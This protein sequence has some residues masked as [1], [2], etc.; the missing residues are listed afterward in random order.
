[1]SKTNQINTP[2]LIGKIE[3]KKKNFQEEIQKILKTSENLDK[4]IKK[5]Y[6]TVELTQMDATEKFKSFIEP[7]K[8]LD[9]L[10]NFYEIFIQCDNDF[11]EIK[12]K[13]IQITNLDQAIENLENCRIL[14]K[15]KKSLN[16]YDN[17]LIVKKLLQENEEFLTSTIFKFEIVFFKNLWENKDTE[18]LSKISEFLME[19]ENNKDFLS[20]YSNELFN[21]VSYRDIEFNKSKLLERSSNIDGYLDEINNYNIKVLGEKYG[22]S[23]NLGLNKILIINLTKII[24]DNLQVIEREE[25]LEDVPFLMELNNNLK[26]NEEKRIKEVESLFVFKDP[27]NKIICNIFITYGDDVNR[28]DRPNKYCDVE[29]LA[30]NLR[31][32][33]DS[34]NRYKILTNVFLRNYGPMFKIKTLDECNETFTKMLMIKILK[35]S[36]TLP[37]LKKYIY[38]INNLY[39]LQNYIKPDLRNKIQD[40][41]DNVVNTFKTELQKRNTDKLTSFIDS[42]IDAFKTYYLPDEIRIKVINFFKK[43]IWE[44]IAKKD[45]KGNIDILNDSIN[46]MFIG[47]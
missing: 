4:I 18:K 21:K 16:F 28:L 3:H 10:S 36:E 25:K 22:Q 30:L 11:H 27:I 34:M 29:H 46:N 32:A 23:I 14:C 15:N 17:I 31:R 44:E 19:Q 20:K 5:I 33:L 8:N 41:I 43:Y 35:F 42:N 13:K 6:K 12:N 39:T 45:Y 37:D 7:K 9:E 40:S 47:K 24:G 26:H 1:M 38:L 2:D